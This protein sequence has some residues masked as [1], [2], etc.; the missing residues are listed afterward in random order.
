MRCTEACPTGAL[1]PIAAERDVIRETVRMGV[2]ELRTDRCIAWTQKG[3]CRA[4]LY[5]CPFPGEAVRLDGRLLA[6]VF[7]P[8]RCVGCGQCEEACPE[9]ARAIRIRPRARVS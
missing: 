4:C 5:A 6:P 1:E 8:E 3:E 9:R 2:P 7:D